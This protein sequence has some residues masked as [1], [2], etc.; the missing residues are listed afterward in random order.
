MP[1]GW[2]QDALETLAVAFAEGAPSLAELQELTVERVRDDEMS[3][4]VVDSLEKIKAAMCVRGGPFEY[5]LRW[6]G[7]N[8]LESWERFLEPW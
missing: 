2:Q 5:R 7:E 3:A 6:E 4:P 1:R 8:K